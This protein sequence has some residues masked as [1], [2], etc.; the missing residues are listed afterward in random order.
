MAAQPIEHDDP[1]D[2]VRILADLPEGERENFLHVYRAAMELAVADPAEWVYVLRVLRAWR[3]LA[4]RLHDP[5]FREAQERAR[6]G[7]GHWTPFEDAVA[8]Y[9]QQRG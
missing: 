4:G 7:T 9:R 1:V 2:P 3:Y 8:A 5:A 6:T